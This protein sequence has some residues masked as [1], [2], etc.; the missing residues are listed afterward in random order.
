MSFDNNQRPR[1]VNNENKHQLSLL[2]IK[3]MSIN[4]PHNPEDEEI[5]PT[6]QGG[7]ID[8]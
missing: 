3:P 2:R 6:N 4:T 8:E 5:T 7:M 1:G